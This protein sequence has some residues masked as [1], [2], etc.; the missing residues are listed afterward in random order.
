MS[1]EEARAW[2]RE[3]TGL[4]RRRLEGKEK[5]HTLTMLALIGPTVITNNQ[6]SWT[7]DYIHFGKHWSVTYF[8]NDPDPIVE[9]I[10]I[11]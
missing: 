6:H 7:D 1:K 2:D 3:I 9:E 10:E 5:E 8:H 4:P 11:E